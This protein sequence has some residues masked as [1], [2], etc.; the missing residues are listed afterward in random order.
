MRRRYSALLLD[1]GGTVY[2]EG[3]HAIEH[4]VAALG[5]VFPGLDPEGR[6]RLARA[7]EDSTRAAL[8][9]GIQHSDTA[10]EAVLRGF[11]GLGRTSPAR[12][13]AAMVESMY[14]GT[15]AFEGARELLADAHRLGLVTVL[16]TDTS[17]H[18]EGDTWERLRPMG[19]A[20][21]LD[22][23]VASFDLGV[24]KPDRRIF[25]AALHR[26][27]AVPAEAIMV[28]DSEANDIAPSAAL[29]MRTIR[30]AV[31][32]PIEAETVAD[33]TAASLSEVR[34]LISRWTVA[35]SS[36]G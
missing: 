15:M 24:R 34:D 19:L 2:V 28:G 25:E 36:P 13:R 35:A 30:V 17:W 16:V 26:A 18:T 8:K 6:E 3:M 33:A 14:G 7:F 29:G 4:R 10:I 20:S 21:E 1:A 12:V 31:Q 23:V 9:A 22:H 27:G 32:Y 11:P 5:R